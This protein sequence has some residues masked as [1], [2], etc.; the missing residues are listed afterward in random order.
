MANTN[1]PNGFTPVRTLS[2]APWSGKVKE[3]LI[4][5]ADGTAVYVGQPVKLDGSSGAAGTVV[6][7]RNCEGMATCIAAAAGD[8]LLGVVVGFVADPAYLIPDYRRASTNRIALVCDDADVVYQAQE[9]SVGGS[10]AAASVGL[11][12]DMVVGSGSTATGRSGAMLDSS[13]V[14]TD[15]GGQFRLLGLVRIPDA[16]STSGEN[17]LGNYAKWEVVINEPQLSQGY[18]LDI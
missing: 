2:G 1:R 4:P 13:D 14:A 15:T 3:Y 8:R 7:G 5:S 16:T 17:Q 10:I 6:N 11:S 12:T 18:A 9:D